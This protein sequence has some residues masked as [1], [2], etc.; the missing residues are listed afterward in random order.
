MSDN[1]SEKKYTPLLPYDVTR[2]ERFEAYDNTVYRRDLSLF[3]NDETKLNRGNV[4]SVFSYQLAGPKKIG[5]DTAS[6]E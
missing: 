3:D 5:G 2:G 1:T 6:E 4:V